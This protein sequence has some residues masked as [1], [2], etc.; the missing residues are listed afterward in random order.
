[1]KKLLV[2]LVVLSLSIGFM[3]SCRDD[4]DRRVTIRFSMWDTVDE[5]AIFI[6]HGTNDADSQC[7]LK[8]SAPNSCMR[9]RILKWQ[10]S[11]RGS[12]M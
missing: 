9:R 4:G 7:R 11:S 3:T 6:F 2:L 1:M 8:G 5:N 12:F 10:T